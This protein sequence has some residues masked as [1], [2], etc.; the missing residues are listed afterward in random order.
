[1]NARHTSILLL[2]MSV[3]L[4][5]GACKKKVPPPPPPAP[6]PPAAPAPAAKPSIT[7][8]AEP[9]SIDRGQSAMLRWN[10]TNASEISI[11]QGIGTVQA[12][13]EQRV[14]PNDTTT[15]R[16]TARGAGGTEQA[17]ATVNVVAPPPPPPP[18]PAGPSLADR[19]A[20]LQDAYFDFDKSA[21]R[22]DARDALTHDAEA[23]KSILSDFPNAVVALEGYCDDRGSAEYNLALGDRRATAAKEFIVQLGVSADRIKTVSYG[24]ERPVCSEQT[25]ECWQ[26]NR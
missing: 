5:A 17:T 10:V 25:E 22:A 7:F 11:N 8:S 20:Q 6:P 19:L 12:S 9:S 24:K 15:Y 4:L 23:L 21:I 1:M 2:G 13:G 16:L 14:S 26:K 3:L 18:K